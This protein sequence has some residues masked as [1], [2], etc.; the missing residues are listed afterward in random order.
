MKREFN[1]KPYSR[2]EAILSQEL[3]VMLFYGLVLWREEALGV[4]GGVLTAGI[5]AF[6]VREINEISENLSEHAY[7]LPCPMF[8]IL[9][10]Q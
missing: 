5:K 1:L 7:F 3:S 2:L 4:Y 9:T 6:S 10:I 8:S